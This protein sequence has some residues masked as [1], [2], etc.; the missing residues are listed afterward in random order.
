MAKLTGKIVWVTGAGTGIGEG[1]ALA[2]AEE[3]ASLVLTGRRPG[4][5][6]E[7]AARINA[8]GGSAYVQ[9]GDM[10]SAS[11]VKT[12]ADWIEAKFGRLDIFVANAGINILE[13]GWDQITAE[14]IDTVLHGNLDSVFYGAIAV[15]PIM[16]RQQDGQIIV[17]ASMAGRWVGLMSG[18]AYVAAKHG[19][20][21]ACHTINMQEC[22]N[23]IR[24]TAV[25]P[26][27][28]A[29]PILDKRPV[30]VSAEERGRMAQKEDV[31]DLIRYIACLPPHVVINEVMI[32]PTWNRGYVSGLQ[33]K[34]TN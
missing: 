19:V 32:C 27:E 16:R 25:L 4:P 2:L 14:G 21:A 15:L 28:V 10:T 24:C 29:T 30:P 22:V 9:A 1:A 31:G 6:E 3:G 23:G 34:G 18:P 11:S 13:R 5:L 12:I 7:V 33:R 8:S 20:V 17:T 26:G